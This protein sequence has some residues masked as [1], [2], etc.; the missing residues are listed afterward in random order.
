M[1]SMHSGSNWNSEVLAFEERG[2]PEYPG[3]T[4]SGQRKNQYISPHKVRAQNRT[5]AT[6]VA[7]NSLS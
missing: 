1:R 4:L 3:E 6:L 7:V 2:K 5:R